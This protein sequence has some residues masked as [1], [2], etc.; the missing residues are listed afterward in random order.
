LTDRR[1][2]W[3]RVVL[4]A[5]AVAGILVS[6]VLVRMSA[7][8]RAPNF[9][10]WACGGKE[11][12]C[13]DVLR[14]NYARLVILPPRPI[15]LAAVGTAYFTFLG[16]WLLMIGRMPG[17][18]QNAWAVPSCLGLLGLAASGLMVYLMVKVVKTWCGLC[19]L[20]HA[21]NFPLVIGIW[22]LWLIPGPTDLTEPRPGARTQLWRLPVLAIIAG[23]AIGLAQ[24]RDVQTA[25]AVK[26]L[27]TESETA[28]RIAYGYAR[29]YDIPVGPDDPV[30]GPASAAHTVVVFSD[31]QCPYCGRFAPL[32]HY[33]Q[34][35]L[36]PGNDISRAPFKIVWKHYPLNPD[37][38]P[39]RK[40]LMQAFPKAKTEHE[41]ACDAAAAAEAARLL[42]GNDAFWK[43]HDLL[44]AGQSQFSRHP[45]KQFASQIGLD[46]DQF[47][48]VRKDPATLQR[49]TQ[50][51]ILGNR[52]GVRTTPTV[53]L[54]GRRVDRP[55]RTNVHTQVRA[56]TVEHWRNLLRWAT[57]APRAAD[58]GA[59]YDDVFQSLLQA[60]ATRPAAAT[61]TPAA[62]HPTTAT[63]PQAPA[64]PA[65]EQAPRPAS[66]SST[67]LAAQPAT[68]TQ[69]T[70][71]MHPAPAAQ[72]APTQPLPAPG[73]PS[74]PPI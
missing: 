60:A 64:T 12:N 33:V 39:G 72:K 62:S 32:L 34:Q 44:F 4:L 24:L 8:G 58:G 73:S 28:D 74:K 29:R 20:T 56:D 49:V 16:L 31:F 48:K 42:G 18:L 59:S 67:S 27:Q 61:Q 11:F 68:A 13:T 53:F 22:I 40:A 6:T 35:S 26:A 14:S 1:F 19:L 7:G 41:Y 30:R 9:L 65:A 25:E 51:A 70:V 47:E 43:M 46:P 10:E 66:R 5:L 2:D 69:P 3:L 17:R 15:P 21:I 71:T 52:L 45:Y 23:A 37:C 38:N 50:D 36:S 54:D 63:R 57:I 55:V